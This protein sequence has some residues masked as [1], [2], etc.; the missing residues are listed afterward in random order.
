VGLRHFVE[1]DL[2]LTFNLR[3]ISVVNNFQLPE[4]GSARGRGAPA[5]RVPKPSGGKAVSTHI[6]LDTEKQTPQITDGKAHTDR[7]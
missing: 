6:S 5:D 3:V 2:G 4:A 7:T 1:N